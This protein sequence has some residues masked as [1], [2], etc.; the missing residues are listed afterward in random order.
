MNDFLKIFYKKE[1]D[2]NTYIILLTKLRN[3]MVC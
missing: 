1:D 3:T 2:G